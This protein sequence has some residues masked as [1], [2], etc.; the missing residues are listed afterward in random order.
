MLRMGKTNLV[1]AGFQDR[2]GLVLGRGEQLPFADAT[3][4]AVTFTYLLR[5]V[6]DPEATL[7]ELAGCLKPGGAIANLEFAVPPNPWWRAA[8]WCYT[9]WILPV[10]GFLSGGTGWWHVGRF[11]GPI[12]RLSYRRFSL[13]W[14]LRAWEHAGVGASSSSY[15]SRRWSRNVGLP[16]E[17]ALHV[18]GSSS[19]NGISSTLPRFL[20][21]RRRSK[22]GGRCFIR[23]TPCAT[24]HLSLSPPGNARSTSFVS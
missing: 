16:G 24:F 5:Y 19:M 11:L 14:T 17:L 15:E 1:K 6:E 20:R 3:F 10:A 13:D 4:D 2:V 9:R 21:S 22:I 12:I 23:P 18:L 8:W 7:K